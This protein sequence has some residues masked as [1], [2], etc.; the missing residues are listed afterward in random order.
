MHLLC[1]RQRL[2][3]TL[4]GL[5]DSHT[6]SRERAWKDCTTPG[7]VSSDTPP[8][9]PSFYPALRGIPWTQCLAPAAVPAGSTWWLGR[10]RGK[11]RVGTHVAREREGEGQGGYTHD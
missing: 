2:G 8:P 4:L 7:K 6:V 5:L 10:E 1:G 9:L 3:L 11:D